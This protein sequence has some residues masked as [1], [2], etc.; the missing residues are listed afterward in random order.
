MPLLPGKKNIGNNIKEM[1]KSGHPHNQSVAAALNKAYDGKR[2]KKKK[3]KKSKDS[4]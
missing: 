4:T 2:S 1:E 3:T